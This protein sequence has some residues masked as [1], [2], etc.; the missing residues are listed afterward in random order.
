MITDEYATDP[1]SRFK[2]T[3]LNINALTMISKR[4]ENDE[5]VDVFSLFQNNNEALAGFVSR[6]K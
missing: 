6:R 3:N 1:T 4:I 2:N 5:R